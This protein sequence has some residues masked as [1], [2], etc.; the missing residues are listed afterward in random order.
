[1][2]LVRLEV[3]RE[4]VELPRSSARG[5]LRPGQGPRRALGGRAAVEISERRDA[6]GVGSSAREEVTE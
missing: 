1:M 2:E 4:R 6:R 3:A 5:G